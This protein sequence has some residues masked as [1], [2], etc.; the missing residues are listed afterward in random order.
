MFSLILP[1]DKTTV[2]DFCI[3]KRK[4]AFKL[5]LFVPLY[6]ENATPQNVF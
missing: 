2:G 4:P 5:Y 6:D 3:V 1:H